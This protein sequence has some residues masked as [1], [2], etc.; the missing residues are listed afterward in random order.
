[1]TILLTLYAG[2]THAFETDH[3]LAVSNMVTIRNKTFKAIKDGMY[4][5]FGHTSTILLIGIIF[6]L[7][8]FKIAPAT[9]K[10]FEAAVGVM[11]VVLGIY[12][13]YQWYTKEEPV[14]HTHPNGHAHSH[15]HIHTVTKT[16]KE[17][18]CWPAYLIGLIHGLAGSGALILIVLGNSQTIT[19][20]LIYL[21]L[22]GLGSVGGMMI[23][24][25]A[26]SLPFS[27]KIISNNMLQTVLIFASAL[28]CIGYGA[29]VIKE[30]LM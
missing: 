30:N 13:I 10:Y 29:M 6:L 24:A 9:F 1:M 14:L 5:G 8:K 2:F 12:R 4:W 15:T 26:F 27:K 7:L 3:I 23:A 19:N 21:L 11:L 28:L 22:F 17:H 20:G 18:S 25:G 16:T